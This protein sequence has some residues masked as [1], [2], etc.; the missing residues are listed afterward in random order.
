MSSTWIYLKLD[1]FVSIFALKVTAADLNLLRKLKYV[2]A[3]F[4]IA[5]IKKEQDT[6]TSDDV[7]IVYELTPTPEQRNLADS[8]RLPPTFFCYKSKPGYL[9]SE[10]DGK[11]L[12]EK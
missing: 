4:S 9:S 11:N 7:L 12:P 3:F 10:D 2:F 5:E 8:L 1:Y 6:V